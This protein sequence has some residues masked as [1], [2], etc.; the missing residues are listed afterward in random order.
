MKEFNTVTK[1]SS[2]VDVLF[3]YCYPSTYRAGMTGLALHILY[4]TLNSRE[5][6]SCERYFRYDTSSPARSVE[7]NRPLRDNH[8]LGYSLT[9]EEDILH[10]VQM[11]EIGNVP[12][13]AKNRGENDP[14]V[15]VGGP[16]V[17]ANPEPYIDFIDAFVIG[18]GDLIIHDIVDAIRD[19][20]TRNEALTK[21]SQLNG[22]YVPTLPKSSIRRNIISNLDIL[23]YPTTQIVADVVA[24]SHLESVFGRSFLL[25]VTRGC[26]HSC[27]F[28]LVGHICRPRRTRSLKRL[29]EIVTL[30]RE[31]TPTNKISMIGSS[32]GDLDSLED[33]VCWTV[34]QGLEVSV[35]SLRADSVSKPLLDCLVESGQRTLT[36]APESG[37]ARLRKLMGKGLDE[38]DIENAADLAK[39][40]GY[41]ALKLY[42]IVGLPEETDEDLKETVDMITKLART[43][44]K[45]TASVNPFIP[46]AQTRWEKEP[47]PPIEE[48]RRKVSFV[49]RGVREISRV[50]VETLDPRN[51]RIQAALS[52]GDRTLGQVIR[53]ASEY[54]GLGGWRRAERETK[55]PFFSIAN[56]GERLEGEL[57]WSFLSN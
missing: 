45:V 40:T 9:Y 22:I 53:K 32:L 42:F 5:D 55:I 48:I 23:P 36:I 8:I 7:S 3:G 10:L 56:D 54:G 16:V 15:I 34:E 35:P 18:E 20:G 1:D 31:D 27:R 2:R 47:Q 14:I 57:P 44:L 33:F 25:E 43:G 11:L 12:I 29:K 30:G 37:S 4:A 52:L 39:K 26:G 6:T 19:C 51:A 13:V 38:S 49:E 46:K 21:L 28:C 24:G 50:T 17:T 41:G